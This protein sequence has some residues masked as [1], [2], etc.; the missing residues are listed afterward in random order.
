MEKDWKLFRKKLG[1]WQEAY[2]NKLIEE[3]KD[4]LNSDASSS[5]KYWSLR[6]KIYEDYKSPGVLARDVSRSNMLIILLGLLRDEA[7]TMD[8]LDEFSD[9]LKEDIKQCIK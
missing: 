6:K 3:Y 1:I 9:E 8:D 5:D 7:I 2:M 4:I